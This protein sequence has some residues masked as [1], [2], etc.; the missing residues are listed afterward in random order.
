MWAGLLWSRALL[1]VATILFLTTAI[2]TGGRQAWQLFRS[3]YWLQ[4]MTLLFWMP[5]LSGL[6]S[7]DKHQW[8]MLMQEKI[9][10]LLFPFA[11]FVLSELDISVR[12]SL[13]I[14]LCSML[15]LSILYS[16]G[17]YYANPGMEEA[18]LRAKVLRVVMSDDHV[19]Y[20]WLLL[21]SLI[22]VAAEWEGRWMEWGYSLLTIFFLHLLASKTGLLGFYLLL[23]CWIF[24]RMRGWKRWLMVSGVALLPLLAWF[25]LPSFQNRLRF[26]WW[27][28][29]QYS[30][31]GY[32]E[33][34]SDTPRVFSFRGGLDLFRRHWQ[35]GMG[36]GDVKQGMLEWYGKQAP[37][38]K[39]YEQ[40]MPSNEFLFM[41]VS[42]GILSVFVMLTFMV[43]PFFMRTLRGFR[44]IAFHALMFMISLYE[45]GLQTQYGVF[46]YG[47][48]GVFFFTMAVSD[49]RSSRSSTARC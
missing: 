43:Y 20:A 17:M 36:M 44:W 25:A 47:F 5:F 41:G 26:V 33:G 11:A 16:M 10:L 4:G 13:K 21:L 3:S 42:A 8:G 39:P 46:L 9:P 35:S 18:Y 40:L 45:I 29:Q 14:A 12:R 28:F 15:I 27:D 32:V 19:R 37:F 49:H 22:W 38:L 1:S 6:W 34:L 31:G 7:A 30:R 23:F 48:F 2:L 24:F